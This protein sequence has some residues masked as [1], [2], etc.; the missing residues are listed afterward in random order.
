LPP[1]PTPP[2]LASTP[3]HRPPH[4]RIP[5]HRVFRS[6]PFCSR[7]TLAQFALIHFTHYFLLCPICTFAF[8]LTCCPSLFDFHLHLLP[9]SPPCSASDLQLS[10]TQPRPA[11]SAPEWPN[12]LVHAAP[13]AAS[14]GCGGVRRSGY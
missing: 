10:R 7:V 14:S 9:V 2:P 1:H 11:P 13:T 8:L 3:S 5:C 6:L 12:T 4:H